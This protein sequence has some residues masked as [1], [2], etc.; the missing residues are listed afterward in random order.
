MIMVDSIKTEEMTNMPDITRY[1]YKRSLKAEKAGMPKI[2]IQKVDGTLSVSLQFEDN[3]LILTCLNQEPE[4]LEILLCDFKKDKSRRCYF[5]DSGVITTFGDTE[6]VAF[7][8]KDEN[9]RKAQKEYIRNNKRIKHWL[10][11]IK[12]RE[13]RQIGN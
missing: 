7:D 4:D 3:G 11:M 1:K 9:K 12:R 10:K 2:R 5:S 6:L 13:E 8:Y